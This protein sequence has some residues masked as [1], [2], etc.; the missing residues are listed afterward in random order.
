VPTYQYACTACGHELEAVQS[1]SDESLTECP[2]CEGR[3]RK[4]FGSVGVVFKGSGFYRTDSRSEAT[5]GKAKSESAES[6]ATSTASS[7]SSS[8]S[9]TAS[10]SGPKESKTDKG[11][12]DSKGSS[13]APAAGSKSSKKPV[14]TGS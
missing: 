13:A 12:K 7:S 5:A 4:V 3:L 14:A 10:S 9:D 6:S 1:F 8:S 11:A 2:T